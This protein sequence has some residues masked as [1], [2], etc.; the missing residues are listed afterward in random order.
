M[1]KD[2]RLFFRDTTQWSQLIL[3]AALL[4]VYLFNIKALPLFRGEQVPFFLV[5]VVSF[6]NLGL[7]GFVLAVHR[8]ALHLPGG[9]PRG[10][11][12]VAAAQLAARPAG[13]AVV[14]VLGGDAPAAGAGA[15]SSPS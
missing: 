6:L 11:A 10:A 15:G 12:D 14:E 2:L 5:S 13:A 7:A 8:G 1:L 4:F 3:L 9:E